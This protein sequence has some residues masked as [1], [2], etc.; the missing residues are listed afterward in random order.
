[1][2]VYAGELSQRG[3]KHM[4]KKN[5]AF[6]QD[7]GLKVGVKQMNTEEYVDKTQRCAAAQSTRTKPKLRRKLRADNGDAAPSSMRGTTPLSRATKA[8]SGTTWRRMP[9]STL[10]PTLYPAPLLTRSAG[11]Q[12]PDPGLQRPDPGRRTRARALLRARRSGNRWPPVGFFALTI[13]LVLEAPASDT[14]AIYGAP[15]GHVC[16]N[17]SIAAA[18]TP[19]YLLHGYRDGKHQEMESM[20]RNGRNLF[21]KTV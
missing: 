21:R 10:F 17:S 14:C 12:R 20:D 13:G 3:K 4:E 2:S 8:R 7:G 5:I 1:M 19:A 16:N 11:R 6:T 15:A 18:G 9:T